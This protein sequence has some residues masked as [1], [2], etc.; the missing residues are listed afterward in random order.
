M[1]NFNKYRVSIILIF[2][3]FI[4]LSQTSLNASIFTLDPVLPIASELAKPVTLTEH[5]Q[6]MRSYINQ[7]R[8]MHNR[9]F[10]LVQLMLDTPSKDLSKL[11]QNI[12]N[13]NLETDSMRLKMRSYLSAVLFRTVIDFSQ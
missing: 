12:N 6:T 8:S 10:N 3:V 5:I 4:L 7:L 9:I 1:K 2:S 13:I 11:K